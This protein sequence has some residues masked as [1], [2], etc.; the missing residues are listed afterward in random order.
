M[1]EHRSSTTADRPS[2]CTTASTTRRRGS[3]TI[4]FIVGGLFVAVA[5]LAFAMSGRDMDATWTSQ[6]RRR[7]GAGR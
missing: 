7:A 2:S 6:A 1:E 4:W 5:I 3:G